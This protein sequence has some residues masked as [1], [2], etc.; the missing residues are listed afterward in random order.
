MV[1]PFPDDVK[2]LITD[3]L[4]SID[5]LEILLLLKANPD[6]K[7]SPEEVSAELYTRPEAARARLMD[8]VSKNLAKSAGD[9]LLFSYR[10]ESPEVADIVERLDDLYRKRRVT[11]I[12]LIYSKSIQGVQAF[13]DAF[14]IR[15]EKK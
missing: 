12:N 5:Q 2:K 8:L 7:Y 14:Q 9:P 1:D 10:P 6:H 4:S 11:V 3:R 13:A 15:K